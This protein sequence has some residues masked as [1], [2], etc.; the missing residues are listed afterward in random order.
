MRDLCPLAIALVLC[1]LAT[2]ASAQDDP[3][4]HHDDQ[5]EHHQDASIATW[6]WAT[7]ANVFVGYNYQERHFAD[8]S[9]WESQNW[10]MV[11]GAHRLG[12][13]RLT[14]ASMLSLEPFTMHAHGSPQLFQTG[15]SYQRMPLLNYQHPH[16]L[17]M[18]LG[19]TYERPVGRLRSYLGADLVGS[20][21]LGPIPFMHRESARSNPQVPL[22]HH[23]MDAT[24]ITTGVIRGGVAFG[25]VTV[26]SSAFRGQE[27]DEDRLNIERPRLDSWA[28]R[29]QYNAGPWHAQFSGGHLH[30][31]EWFD[32][33]DV[34]LL[35]ASVGF[36]GEVKSHPLDVTVAWGGH[37][38]FNGF[39]GNADGY[40]AEGQ[41]GV[42]GR[43]TIY[44]RAEYTG[45]DLF[46]D[47]H[48]KGFSHRTIIYELGA[49]TAGYLRDI[50]VTRA[51][52]FGVG[53]DATVYQ[54]PD[55]LLPFWASSRSFHVFLRWRP[56]GVVP[57]SH[58]NM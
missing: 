10:F 46:V 33:F 19:A 57:H 38:E 32:P 1:T 26:E 56:V 36:D 30:Q 21:T 54:I 53:A 20:P 5:P 58:M 9:A 41:L 23:F 51:G 13:G 49:F 11:S 40:L 34:T 39:N 2:T 17:V 7:D 55:I 52:R 28:V 29:A 6:T 25:A 24:H 44:W 8:F 4:D 12:E 45:K 16:D 48:P 35:T 22:T 15:E 42:S 47:V 37:R 3:S 14:F 18:E 31:P 27:P 50:S 43:S